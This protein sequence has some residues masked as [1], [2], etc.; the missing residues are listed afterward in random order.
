M[1]DS[2]EILSLKIKDDGTIYDECGHKVTQEGTGTTSILTVDN[3]KCMYFNNGNYLKVITD[4]KFNLTGDFTIEFWLKLDGTTI[5]KSNNWPCVLGTKYAWYTGSTC[6]LVC[7]QDWNNQIGICSYDDTDY[8][9]SYDY[10]TPTQWNYISIVCKDKQYFIYVNGKLQ[11]NLS[12]NKYTDGINLN[13]DGFIT[14]GTKGAENFSSGY[15]HGYLSDFKI[16]T[17]AKYTN[18]YTISR[19]IGEV[20]L[21][22]DPT[23]QRIDDTNEKL[24]YSK[25]WENYSSD[26]LYENSHHQTNIL[27]ESVTF[28]F[29]GSKLRIINSINND[30]TKNIELTIDG[31]TYYYSEYSNS[32]KYKILI[33]EQCNLKNTFHKVKITNTENKYIT[34]DCLDIDENGHLVTEEEYNQYIEEHK[35]KSISINKTLKNNLPKQSIKDIEI[36][37]TEDGEMYVNKQ[38]GSL[39]K[40]NTLYESY[41]SEKTYNVN[42]YVIYNKKLYK[43]INNIN[44]SEEFDNTKWEIILESENGKDAPNIS[45]L[46]CKDKDLYVDFDNKTTKKIENFNFTIDTV[47]TSD[48]EDTP[49]GQIISY[50]GTKAPAHYLI[51]D[52]SIYN[53]SDYQKLADSFKEQFGSY[54]YFGGDGIATFAVP[55][56]RNEFIRGYHGESDEKLSGDIGKHQDATIIQNPIAT[57]SSNNFLYTPIPNDVQKLIVENKNNSDTAITETN[58][59]INKYSTSFEAQTATVVTSYTTRPTN[60][61]VLFCIKYENTYYA[62]IT[63]INTRKETVLYDEKIILSSQQNLTYTLKESITNFDRIKIIGNLK[64][65]IQREFDVNDLLNKVI[66]CEFTHFYNTSYYASCPCGFSDEN[67]FIIYNPYTV[68][69]SLTDMYIYK[70]IGIKYNSISNSDIDLTKSYTDDEVNNAITSIIDKY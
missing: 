29:Y 66:N 22:S 48:M 30:R 8:I 6:I 35:I 25:G 52:G 37:F 49:I 68:G 34:L 7:A 1:T 20:L 53:I 23:W 70:I 4:E 67:T 9:V 59:G 46:Y 10:N 42:D 15:L 31:N 24:I 21:S 51:C 64:G 27:N 41:S 18:N 36:H 63:N 14:I 65:L 69:W 44:A 50:M 3:R 40:V 19:S 47:G 56:L 38:D 28:Y 58:N 54:N 62:N 13:Y 33:F 11:T 57:N 55:D 2:N 61:S 5:N 26:D 60:V 43:C 12:N 17:K 32:I 45:K 16:S 39:T